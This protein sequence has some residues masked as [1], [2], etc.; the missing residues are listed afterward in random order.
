MVTIAGVVVLWPSHSVRGDVS[1]LGLISKVYS[2]TVVKVADGPCGGVSGGSTK[3][4]CAKVTFRLTQGPDTGRRKTIEF[5]DSPST[6]NLSV[7]DEVVLNHVPNAPAGFEYTYNDRQ[8]RPV[9]VWLAIVFAVAVIA[10]GR[11][12]AARRAR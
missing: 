8:R 11:L 1:K 10:L 12:R 5:A 4:K 3:V 9:L 6:P 2:A 7:G